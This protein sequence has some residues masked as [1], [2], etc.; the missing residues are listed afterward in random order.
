MYTCAWQM[1]GT[2]STGP[3]A[4]VSAHGE[5]SVCDKQRL[6]GRMQVTLEPFVV[7]AF[8]SHTYA[9]TQFIPGCYL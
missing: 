3:L 2:L 9:C 5:R 6:A 4:R 1:A 8:R 7:A